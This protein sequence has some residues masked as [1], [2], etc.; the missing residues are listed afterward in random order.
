MVP[1][2]TLKTVGKH[3]QFVSP[4]EKEDKKV[5]HFIVKNAIRDDASGTNVIGEAKF[6]LDDLIDPNLADLA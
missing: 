3:H 2:I 6:E 5:L 1:A 4:S